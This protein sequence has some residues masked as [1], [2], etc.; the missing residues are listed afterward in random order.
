M[1]ATS[2]SRTMVD[3]DQVRLYNV[4]SARRLRVSRKKRTWPARDLKLGA[5]LVQHHAGHRSG[6]RRACRRAVASRPAE[7]TCAE[8][9]RSLRMCTAEPGAGFWTLRHWVQRR[10]GPISQTGY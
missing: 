4:S 7:K 5:F 9:P 10:A 6:G 3:W 1:D 2:R 8:N